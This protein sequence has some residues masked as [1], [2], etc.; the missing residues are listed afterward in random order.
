MTA[1]MRLFL[2]DKQHRKPIQ[3]KRMDGR[4]TH[5]RHAGHAQ[6]LPSEVI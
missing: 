3:S 6:P 5:R 1:A 2:A 4:T